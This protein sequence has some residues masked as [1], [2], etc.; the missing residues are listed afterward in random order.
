MS[1]VDLRRV[2]LEGTQT[3]TNMMETAVEEDGKSDKIR[4]D[5]HTREKK[6]KSRFRH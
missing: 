1:T 6:K 3:R 4:I 2:Y 5:T